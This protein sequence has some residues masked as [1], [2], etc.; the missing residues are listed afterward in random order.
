MIRAAVTQAAS[1][2]DRIITRTVYSLAE[3]LAAKGSDPWEAS[4]F[5]GEWRYTEEG[6]PPFRNSNIRSNDFALDGLDSA[7]QVSI[8]AHQR[9]QRLAQLG[10]H[11]DPHAF[12][13]IVKLL[14]SQRIGNG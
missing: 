1:A 9:Q 4:R 2:V 8:V 11:K 10:S 5:Q 6:Q 13:V 7:M 14:P 12:D 3:S